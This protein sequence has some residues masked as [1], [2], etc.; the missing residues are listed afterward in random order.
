[1]K[2]NLTVPNTIDRT[3]SWHA[4]TLKKR[5]RYHRNRGTQE[6]LD[7]VLRKEHTL[8]FQ[9]DFSSLVLRKKILVHIARRLLAKYLLPSLYSEM[10][11]KADMNL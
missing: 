6:I 1:M 4:N 11:L 7:Q 3:Y 5:R 10:K 8:S 2:K 9:P